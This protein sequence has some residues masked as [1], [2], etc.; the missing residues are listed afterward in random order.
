MKN[1]D[2]PHH[3]RVGVL[4][5][6]RLLFNASRGMTRRQP[7]AT[8][9][10]DLVNRDFAA[11]KPNQLWVADMTQH[12]TDEGWLYLA[13]VVDVFSRRVV[14]W[15]MGDRPVADLAVNAVNMAIWNRRPVRGVIHHS[16][17]GAQYT[18]LA[19][20]RTL[21]QSLSN[22]IA[23]QRRRYS[24]STKPLTAHPPAECAC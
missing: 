8:P 2:K 18:S 12:E 24:L 14:G 22:V 23:R 17:H 1:P 7:G 16:D 5:C 13:V 19:F 4:G 15:S 6:A 11:S 20:G 21:R 10:P 9:Q 3:C